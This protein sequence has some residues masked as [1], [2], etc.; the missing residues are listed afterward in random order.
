MG[1]DVINANAMNVKNITKLKKSVL[2]E[3]KYF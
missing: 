3:K 1:L 2:F